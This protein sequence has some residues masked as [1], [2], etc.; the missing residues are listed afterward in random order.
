MQLYS[1]ALLWCLMQ[2]KRSSRRS[3]RLDSRSQTKLTDRE[4]PQGCS[5]INQNNSEKASAAEITVTADTS[6]SKA[7]SVSSSGRNKTNK[8]LNNG[9][10]LA[11]S[12]LSVLITCCLF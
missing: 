4:E 5:N 11:R 12:F 1:L 3:S 2:K 9:K 6:C 8:L 10:P 7:S